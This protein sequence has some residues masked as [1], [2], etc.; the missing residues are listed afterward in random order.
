MKIIKN[1]NLF[2]LLLITLSLV[3]VSCSEETLDLNDDWP[4][5]TYSLDAIQGNW[6]RIGGNYPANNGM[7]VNVNNDLGKLTDANNS[8]FTNGDLKWKDIVA[9]GSGQYSY[10][11]LGNDYNYYP[12]TINFGIDDTLRVSVNNAGAGNI[13]KWVREANYTPQ[14]AYLEVLQGSWIRVGGNYLP[15]NG[16][17]V[18][19]DENTGTITDP[20]LSDFNLGAI[21]WSNIYALNGNSFMYEELGNDSN[22]YPATMELGVADTLRIDVNNGGAGNVQKW[23]RQ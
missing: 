3:F 18:D 5:Q 7:K 17:V 23:I 13:Q 2:T 6:I 4:Q 16:V 8:D 20:A 9:L 22:Y 19:V 1:Y 15:N 21:K 10:K 14:S 11:E 12:S